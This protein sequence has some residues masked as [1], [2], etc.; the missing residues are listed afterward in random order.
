MYD[1]FIIRRNRSSE[2]ICG[3]ERLDVDRRYASMKKPPLSGGF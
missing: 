1:R 2:C 3:S